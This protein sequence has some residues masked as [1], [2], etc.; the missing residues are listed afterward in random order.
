VI[1]VHRN[2]DLNLRHNFA[3]H[4]GVHELA[5]Y[6][7]TWEFMDTESHHKHTSRHCANPLGLLDVES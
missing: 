4:T 7:L 3:S 2:S 1:T 6:H 5:V